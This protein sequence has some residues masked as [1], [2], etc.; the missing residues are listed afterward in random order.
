[1]SSAIECVK[2]I[3]PPYQD[4]LP[5]AS[6]FAPS[7]IALIKYWGKRD[8]TI[9]LPVTDSISLGNYGSQ[10]TLSRAEQGDAVFLNTQPVDKHS[11]FFRRAQTFLSLFRPSPDFYFK[12]EA[13]SNIPIAAGLASSAS[14]FASIT[15]A[16]NVFFNWQLDLKA[17]SI[18]ARLGSGSAAR[19]VCP[20]FMHWHKGMA[21]DGSDAYATRLDVTWPELRLGLLIFSDKPKEKSS[22]LAMKESVYTSPFYQVWP[23]CVEKDL[24][25]I[26]P[27]I[28]ARDFALL[29]STAEQN[30]LAMHACMQTSR[31]ATVYTLPETMKMMHLVW[32]A[33]R[34]GLPVYF[35]QDAGPNLKLLFEAKHLTDVKAHFPEL[36]EVRP[37]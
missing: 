25:Q 6:V 33:R 34:D 12:L 10:A 18:L 31:P 22:R 21:L 11:E 2:K 28:A 16:L 1:M 15:L 24:E 30:A 20:G 19:S 3:I 35:T 4:H 26:L 23:E 5:T 13:T 36:V 9:N 32:K 27:A 8:E 7:N 37:F 14:G 29:G 17:L